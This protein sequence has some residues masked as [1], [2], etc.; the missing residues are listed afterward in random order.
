MDWFDITV[1]D[2]LFAKIKRQSFTQ[3]DMYIL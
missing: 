1:P 2:K 3:I